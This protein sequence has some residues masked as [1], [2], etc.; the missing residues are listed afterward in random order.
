M[1]ITGM[2]NAMA[3]KLQEYSYFHT[4]CNAYV[5][6]FFL[7]SLVINLMLHLK[8]VEKQFQVVVEYTKYLQSSL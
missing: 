2:V 1:T 6:I 5:S 3:I 7:E 8:C 4:I